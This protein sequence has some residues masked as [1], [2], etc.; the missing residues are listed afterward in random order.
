MNWLPWERKAAVGTILLLCLLVAATL[1]AFSWVDETAYYY[2][3]RCQ[4]WTRFRPVK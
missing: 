2:G 4:E 1:K 3:T